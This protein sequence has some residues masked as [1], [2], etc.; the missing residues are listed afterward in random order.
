MLGATIG[1]FLNVVIYRLPRGISLANPPH[2]FCPICKHRLG[3]PD[4]VPLLSWAF[5]GGKC[6]HC[7]AKIAVRY[8]AVELLTGA[9]W[10]GLWWKFLVVGWNPLYGICLAAFTA[11]LVA[12]IF[13]DL[14]LYIIPDQINA[15]LLVPAW[16]YQVAL[17]LEDNPRAWTWG[18]PSALAGMLVGV[19]VL[20]FIAFL[21]RLIFQKDA[22][23]HG[24][25]KMTRGIGA[26]LFPVAAL[27]SFGI[28]IALGAILG[29]LQVI[30]RKQAP[31]A[32]EENQEEDDDLLEPE[33]VGSLLKSGLGYLLCIDVIGLFAP[34]IYESWFGENPYA[35]EV[36][37]HEETSVGATMIPFG[38]YLAAGAIIMVLWEN[39]F[40]GL[41]EAYL[42]WVTGR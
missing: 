10:A 29:V 17:I 36:V 31:Q 25:I 39:W 5:S 28:A 18:L 20:W 4:L 9:I 19:G 33:S 26:M 24:D 1:S 32:E 30:F 3:I 12:A 7:R 41:G 42:K 2:S 13:T 16:V 22:M 21:G 37:E 6:R 14:D 8:F 40:L 38:P 23:G 11:T 34:K 15:F 27:Y 35:V